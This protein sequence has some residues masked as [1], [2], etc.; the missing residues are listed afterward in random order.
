MNNHIST[1][2]DGE[3]CDEEAEVLL[4]KIKNDPDA[5]REW[6]TYHLIGDVLRQPAYISDEMSSTFF[7][8]LH[9]E[10]TVLAPQ[11][12]PDSKTRYF[13]MSAVASIMAMAFLSWLLVQIDGGQSNLHSQQLAQQSAEV[14]RMTSAPV[15]EGMRDYLSAHH[16]FSPSTDV[17]GASS[18]IH[19]VAFNYDRTGK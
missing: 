15:I 10:P 5:N 19:T 8:R 1:L 9:T 18:Y 6:M 17:R 3:L 4:G 11:N 12:K 2:M 14:L 7:E 16:D 13:A